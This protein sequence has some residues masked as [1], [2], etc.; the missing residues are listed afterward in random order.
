MTFADIQTAATTGGY[1]IIAALAAE[2]AY[3]WVASKKGEDMNK[4][5]MEKLQQELKYALR[6]LEDAELK[7]SSAASNYWRPLISDV[8]S[9]IKAGS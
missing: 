6:G 5:A 8:K 2:K 4:E 3:G 9:K 1:A 7:N